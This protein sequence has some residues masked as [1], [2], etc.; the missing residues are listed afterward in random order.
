MRILIDT[1]RYRDFC[2]NV[3]DALRIFQ[4]AE[5]IAIPFLA[6][7]ELRA[8]FMAGSRSRE[9]E[10]VLSSFLNRR[11]VQTLFADEQ[12]TF[13]YSHLFFQLRSQGTMIPVHDIWIA[14]LAVQHG[15]QLFSRDSHFEHL[16]QIPKL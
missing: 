1:N 11:R 4:R 16:P 5:R 8:G 10:Q 14:A 12:T 2:D 15:L 6:L 7:A 9:N 13:H 3:P